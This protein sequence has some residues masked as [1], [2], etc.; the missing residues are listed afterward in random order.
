MVQSHGKLV[1]IRRNLGRC[2]IRTRTIGTSRI[3]R[4]RVSIE[5]RFDRRIHRND[6]RIPRETGRVDPLAFRRRGHRQHLRGS[7]N[8]PE[9]LV[10]AEE[11]GAILSVVARQ[12]H[13][14]SD[15]PAELIA[16]ERRYAATVQFNVVEIIARVERSVAE[17]LEQAA[18]DGIRSRL[19]DHVSET[20]GPVTDL[21]QHHAGTG[22]HFLDGIDIEGGEGSATHFR[23]GGVGSVHGKDRGHAALTVDGKLLRE[24]CSSVGVGH[25]PRRQQEQLAEIA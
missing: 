19:R 16:I 9:P 18:M 24:I 4:Q 22:L 3:V 12:H 23:I 7:K 21:G 20:R 13:R 11:V 5:Y 14:T 10:F 1:V 15:R 8:L 6:E 17:E 2:F 25:G